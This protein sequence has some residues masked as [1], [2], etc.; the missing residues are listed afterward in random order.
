MYQRD[1][2]QKLK[3][4]AAEISPD[5]FE[6]MPAVF[7]QFQAPSLPVTQKKPTATAPPLQVKGSPAPYGNPLS[8]DDANHL[9]RRTGFGASFSSV[10]ALVGLDAT[11]AVTQI[12]EEAQKYE[13]I[14]APTWVDFPLPGEG[15]SQDE[16]DAFINENILQI[17]ELRLTWANKMRSDG[18]RERMT[19]FWH[20]HFVTQVDAYFLATHA[21]RYIHLLESLAVGNFKDLVS[22]IGLSVAMLKYLDGDTNRV[23]A[24]NE[25]YARELLELFTMGQK[26][27]YDADNYSQE[28]ITEAARALTGWII[29]Y[30]NHQSTFI[31]SRFDTTE[32]TFLGRT[33]N[34][35]YNDI[36][37][38]IF[39]ER[40]EQVAWFICKKL[41]EEFVYAEA[42]ET[43][44]EAMAAVFLANDFEIMPVLQLLF[45]SEYFFDPALRGSRIKS[46]VELLVGHFTDA[47]I[48]ELT[49]QQQQTIVL[50][51][52]F[53]QQILLDPP[54]VAGWPGHR[55]WISTT[56]FPIRWLMTD[57]LLFGDGAENQPV[58]FTN[59]ARS[60][61]E[62]SD[63]YA[64]F[65][66]PIA[67]AQFLLPVPLESLKI[68]EPAEAFGGDLVNFPIP[69]FV[70]NGPAYG[71]SLAKMFL[72]GIPWY[73]WNIDEELAPTSLLLFIR[74]LTQIPEYHLT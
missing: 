44:V 73:E 54:N 11:T 50:F 46:P 18:L 39:E 63:Q 45:S 7:E 26:D 29:N 31:A 37:N 12:L 6:G 5:P 62:A 14:E 32:K 74:Y 42:D 1:P 57:F 20:N 67:L 49:Y 58:D 35:G 69:D 40:A 15:A 65:L 21:Y 43:M 13:P 4:R 52:A 48:T 34:W 28:D 56:S 68:P 8:Q 25:N 59:M 2:I 51:S 3:E 17:S 53:L 33:G 9:L 38:L 16:I 72:A 71:V 27:R 22:G 23:E 10:D 60:F 47:D 61:P 64:A 70:T 55:T 66:L 41:F 36:N 24:P 30:G 19:L